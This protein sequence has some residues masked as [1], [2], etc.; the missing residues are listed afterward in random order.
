MLD[1]TF[2]FLSKVSNEDYHADSGLVFRSIHGI[3][4]HL[5]ATQRLWG[6]RLKGLPASQK[7]FDLWEKM[8]DPYSK[9]PG[10]KSGWE[11]YVKDRAEAERGLKA[12][13]SSRRN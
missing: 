1:R 6:G 7:L 11:E 8:E 2:A 3:L 4:C 5:L 10:R 13:V 9:I 12:E